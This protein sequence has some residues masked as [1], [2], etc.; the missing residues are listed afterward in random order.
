MQQVTTPA[1]TPA[2]PPIDPGF[3]ARRV[4][5]PNPMLKWSA[6][7]QAQIAADFQALERELRSEHRDA[8]AMFAGRYQ[9]A[10]RLG[11]AHG[12]AQ[13]ASL[14]RDRH[15]RRN[16]DAAFRQVHTRCHPDLPVVTLAHHDIAVDSLRLG[17]D[18]VVNFG[19]GCKALRTEKSGNDLIIVF[20][21][22]GHGVTEKNFAA[23]LLGRTRQGKLLFGYAK[24][25]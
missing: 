22:R 10:R 6:A 18:E 23:K 4:T 21:G 7:Q 8:D 2:A 15:E 24:L 19:K 17:A 16:E 20:D 13:P 5:R 25:P 14:L 3:L 11:C 1:Q 12:S 9:H